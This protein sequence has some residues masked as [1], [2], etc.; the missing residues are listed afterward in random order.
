M[1]CPLR[2]VEFGSIYVTQQGEVCVKVRNGAQETPIYYSL[3]TGTRFQRDILLDEDVLVRVIT[4][5]VPTK[6]TKIECMIAFF[7]KT[8][9]APDDFEAHALFYDGELLNNLGAIEKHFDPKNH[10]YD[11][12]GTKCPGMGFWFWEGTPRV[13][14]DNK[15]L[16]IDDGRWRKLTAEELLSIDSGLP[17]WIENGDKEAA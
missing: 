6:N 12:Q 1:W 2:E 8:P 16:V 14:N 10:I 15:V 9:D 11:V 5:E 3:T 13:L 17:P 4:I 7:S